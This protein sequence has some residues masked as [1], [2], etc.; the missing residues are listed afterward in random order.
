MAVEGEQRLT[1]TSV[2]DL[3]GFGVQAGD[4]ETAPSSNTKWVYWQ[5][6]VVQQEVEHFK[7]TAAGTLQS[8]SPS[9][10]DFWVPVQESIQLGITY[11]VSADNK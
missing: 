8:H 1:D 2:R 3:E 5:L 4:P 7:H 10:S 11:E 9:Q 6:A